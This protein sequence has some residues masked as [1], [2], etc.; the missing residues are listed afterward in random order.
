M[1]MTCIPAL[2]VDVR[3]VPVVHRRDG[4]VFVRRCKGGIQVEVTE[5]FDDSLGDERVGVR[6]DL[7]RREGAGK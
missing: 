5:P 2:D 7:S 1:H 4:R 6:S 3:G